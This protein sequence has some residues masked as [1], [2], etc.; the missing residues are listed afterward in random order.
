MTACTST[1]I[2]VFMTSCKMKIKTASALLFSMFCILFCGISCVDIN[3]ELGSGFIPTDQRYDIHIDE[4]AIKSI[5]MKPVTELSGYSSSR[6]TIGA[7]RTEDNKLITRSSAFSLIPAAKYDFGE[8]G[9]VA[10]FHFAVAKDTLSYIDPSQRRILQDIYVYA[11]QEPTDDTDGYISSEPGQGEM[12]ADAAIYD[13]GDSLSFDF[14]NEWASEF[15]AKLQAAEP[16]VYDSVG[17]FTQNVFPGIIIK[18]DE[19]ASSGGRINMFTLTTG[20]NL[21]DYTLSG[22]YATLTVQGAEFEGRVVEDTTFMF[23]YGAMDFSITQA[24]TDYYSGETLTPQSALNISS[25]D[26]DETEYSGT[27][28]T[29]DGGGGLKPVIRAREL[30]DRLT[31]MLRDKGIDPAD[32][33]INKATVVM[34]YDSNTPYED[35]DL[36]PQILSPACRITNTEN[37]EETVSYAGIT[38]TSSSSENTGEIDRSTSMYSPDI[39]YHMQQILGLPEYDETD[40][41]ITEQ[42]AEKDIWFMIMAV[43]EQ[44]EEQEGTSEYYQNMQYAMYYNNLYNYGYGGYGYGYGGYGYGG[45]GYNNYYDYYTMAAYYSAMQSAQSSQSS[46]TT[47]LDR[48]RYY[49]AVLRGPEADTDESRPLEDRRVPYLKVTYSVRR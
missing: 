11:L 6:M 31:E 36:F 34:P 24:A 20:A 26:L 47:V 41:D 28:I 27:G 4:F 25:S 44:Q 9:K 23:L 43:E 39:S 35:V 21:S 2:T 48:D 30:R 19:P 45:Y 17:A 3:E 22:G 46:T 14:R 40:S 16:S 8:G 7:I 15:L 38:D 32:V 13:G 29:V 10:R 18:A 5:D 33:I 12:I 37:G 1:I 49:K 42:Y